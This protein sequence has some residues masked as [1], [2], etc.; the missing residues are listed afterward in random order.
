M[1][2]TISFH[3]AAKAEADA[4][5]LDL[6]ARLERLTRLIAAHGLDHLPPKAAKHLTGELWELRVKG[7]DAIARALY[8]TRV[9]QRLVIVRVFVKKTQ[10]TPPR[11]IRL[12]QQRAEEV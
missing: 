1:P 2:W 3:E 7:K 12:A 11:E 6:K 4:L 5:P 9:G 8:V 10:K